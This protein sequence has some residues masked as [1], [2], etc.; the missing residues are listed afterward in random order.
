[1]DYKRFGVSIMDD[2]KRS[3]DR[4][5]DEALKRS[6]QAP[7]SFGIQYLDDCLKGIGKNDFVVLG[8]KT[9]LGKTEAAKI[10][11]LANAAAKRV[12]FFAL[13]AEDGEIEN[14]IKYSILTDLV[15]KTMREEFRGLHFNYTDWRYGEYNEIINK[16]DVEIDQIIT[17]AFPGLHTYYQKNSALTENNIEQTV[18][19]LQGQT[20]LIIIDHLHYFDFDDENEN[21]AM[22]SLVKKLKSLSA[23]CDTPILMLAHLRKTDRR[24]RSASPDLDD[25]HGSSDITKIATKVIMM[26]PAN[27]PSQDMYRFPTFV[28]AVKNRMDN[29]RTR[30]TGLCS[31]DVRKNNYDKT[32][33][34]GRFSVDGQEFEHTS[35]DQTPYWAK[36][37]ITPPISEVEAKSGRN[38][39]RS[40]AYQD[41]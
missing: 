35:T 24:F 23:T 26:G 8:A 30:Y 37:A 18:L 22:K 38:V 32:Y 39:R 13:E 2:L 6:P 21:R 20:D 3:A 17:D 40:R 19:A 25:F 36:S 27:I 7:M 33:Y 9:G 11:A 34:L 31:Y 16:Y 28:S 41:S 14:R 15:Y 4:I 5:K 29:S 10:C 1:M 12:H